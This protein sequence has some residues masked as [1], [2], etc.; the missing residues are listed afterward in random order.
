MLQFNRDGTI[1]CIDAD[2]LE[3]EYALD[4]EDSTAL[5]EHLTSG[6][7]LEAGLT[8]G[9]L[10]RCIAPW[11]STISVLAGVDFE[12]WRQ[13]MTTAHLTVVGTTRPADTDEPPIVEVCIVPR[14]HLQKGQQGALMRI[15]WDALGRLERPHLFAGSSKPEAFVAISLLQPADLVSLPVAILD[16]AETIVDRRLNW[17]LPGRPLV[18]YPTVFDTMI[19]GLLEEIAVY[20]SP[21]EAAS[22]RRTLK[23]IVA[24]GGDLPFEDAR[25]VDHEAD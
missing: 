22:L 6:I 1:T 20:G 21:E 12:P 10:F 8:I 9:G 11:A 23:D 14:F 16:R 15:D 19:R 13:A 7:S 5:L 17:E 3:V 24:D 25:A 2:T 18:V 4:P